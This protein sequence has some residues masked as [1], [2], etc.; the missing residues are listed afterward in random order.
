MSER[1]TRRLEVTA[2]FRAGQPYIERRILTSRKWVAGTNAGGILFTDICELPI[3][4]SES[5][6]NSKIGEAISK[7]KSK[8]P[9]KI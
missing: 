1:D 6:T 8:L 7:V 3:S 2:A 4:R 5:F 9:H